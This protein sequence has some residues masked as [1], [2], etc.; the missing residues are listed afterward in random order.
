M[1]ELHD[2]ELILYYYGEARNAEA[3]RGKTGLSL[4]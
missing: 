4:F 1:N 2:D 3:R